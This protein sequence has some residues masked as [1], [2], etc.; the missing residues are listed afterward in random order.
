[1][2]DSEQAMIRIDMSEY[3]E[4]HS[5]ARLIGAPPGYVGH[6]EGGQ[7]T[8]AAR[9]RPYSVIL[10]DEIEKAHHDVF[11]VLLQILDEGRLTDAQGRTVDFKNTVLIMTSNIGSALLQSAAGSGEALTQALRV[12][13]MEALRGHFRPEFLNRVDEIVIFEPLHKKDLGRIVDIQLDRM[14]KLLADR[15]LALELVDGSRDFLAEHGYDPVYGARPLKRAIQH[16]LQDPLAMKVL[17]GEFLPGDHIQ[18]SAGK[19]EL[20]FSKTARA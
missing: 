8:E 14:R 16:Y 12:E 10:L 15:Q 17:R 5:V 11:N 19:D 3:M 1:M 6:E 20:R 18:V 4:K 9:R 13:M 2:F 7:L